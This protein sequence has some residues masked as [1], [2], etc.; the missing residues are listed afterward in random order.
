MSEKIKDLYWLAM[1]FAD[2]FR[3][4]LL[5]HIRS[6]LGLC[7]CCGKPDSISHGGLC[8]R[9]AAYARSITRGDRP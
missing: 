1:D 6:A 3:S 2:Q 8:E 5:Y 7:V 9:H 4:F